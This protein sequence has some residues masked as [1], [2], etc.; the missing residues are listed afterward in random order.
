MPV[1]F[2]QALPARPTTVGLLDHTQESAGWPPQPTQR[3]NQTTRP[4][5]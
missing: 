3:R 1:V 2:L 5:L 4:Q